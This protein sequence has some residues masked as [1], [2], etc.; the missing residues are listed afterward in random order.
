MK[1]LLVV[2]VAAGVFVLPSVAEAKGKTVNRHQAR[3]AMK[4][5]AKKTERETDARWGVESASAGRCK[6]RK[7]GG[8]NCRLHISGNGETGWLNS[9]TGEAEIAAYDYFFDYRVSGLCSRARVE[10]LDP[11]EERPYVFRVCRAR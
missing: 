3:E 7:R 4:L 5:L 8:W 9:E 11:W 6:K 1:K 2:L 10:I